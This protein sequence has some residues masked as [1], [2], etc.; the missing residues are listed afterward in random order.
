MNA[1]DSASASAVPE[2]SG[3]TVVVTGGASGMGAATARA[4]ARLGAGVV[5]V[6][7]DEAMAS[8][9]GA[10]IGAAAVVV[11]DVSDSGFCD[12]A[13]GTAIA[14]TGRVD[15]L[16]NCAGVI[17][18]A[19]GIDTDDDG[20][21]RVMRVNVDGTFFM[22]RAAL[23]HMVTQRS[24]VIVNFGSIWG[25]IG[26]AGVTAYCA[27]K[28]AVHQITKS[29]ALD[30]ATDGIRINAVAPGEVDTPMLSSGRERRPT[31]ADLQR[32]ADL[33]IPMKRLAQPDEIA[34]VVVF[35]ASDAASYMTGAIIPVDA[36]YTAR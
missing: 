15:V 8:E 9:V 25:G 11:G 12:S 2:F 26:A 32:L 6:D 29:L 18:R 7:R 17:L 13:V 22:C 10:E 28:G 34:S 27:S 33:S 14:D 19:G 35:L 24:G 4:F 16:V 30:H 20:W 21:H 23:R 3:R 36:G 31:D 1:P 5:I